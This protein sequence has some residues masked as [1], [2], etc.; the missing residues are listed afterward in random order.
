MRRVLDVL[1]HVLHGCLAGF[2]AIRFNWLG[3]LLSVFMFTQFL[4]YELAEETK[5]KDELYLELKEW[6]LGFTTGLLCSILFS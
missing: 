2:I 5:L 4:T 6:C 3:L 1:S